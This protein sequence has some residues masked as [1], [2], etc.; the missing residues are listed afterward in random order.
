MYSLVFCLVLGAAPQPV[1]ES[2]LTEA[3]TAA[4]DIVRVPSRYRKHIRYLSF[5]ALDREDIKI[6]IV[7]VFNYHLNSLSDQ[8][9]LTKVNGKGLTGFIT[10]TL[11]RVYVK[12]F[13]WDDK[14]KLENFEKLAEVDTRFHVAVKVTRPG[15][16]FDPK[17]KKLV[18]KQAVKKIDKGISAPWLRKKDMEVLTKY[19]QSK[20]PI[21]WGPWFFTQTA[22]QKGRVAGYYTWFKLKNRND[23]FD[24][25]G[26]DLKKRK[27]LLSELRMVIQKSGVAQRNR[28]VVYYE[29]IGGAWG[30]LDVVAQ[31]IRNNNALLNLN[32]DYKHDA[33][34]W[35]GFLANGLFAY[36]L[37]DDKGV[38][39][40][41]APDEIGPDTTT[42][43]NDGK[44]HPLLSCT[45]CHIE[46]LRPIKDYARELF[47]LKHGKALIPLLSKDEKKQHRLSQLYLRP[48]LPKLNQDV[49]RFKEA[50]EELNGKDWTPAV[51]SQNYQRAWKEWNDDS[52]TLTQAARECGVT[53]SVLQRT[54]RTYY[55]KVKIANLVLATYLLDEPG[56]ILREHWEEQFP[57]VMSLLMGLVP[58]EKKK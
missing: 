45:R 23:Y 19:T 1:Q 3:A 55:T 49:R 48:F 35:F 52:V 22:I 15:F 34:E 7:Y 53:V 56:E 51:N 33:E 16:D 8:S 41:T 36:Y 50:L 27:T 20:A 21:L 54:L 58:E 12:D 32:G 30:T 38:Q 9:K 39:Q 26:L 47:S 24:L 43:S 5:Y 14:T 42:T 13:G 10:P 31:Q 29:G 46:G 28:G 6:W 40:E 17:T 2:P 25:I 57:L 44:I 11:L 18:K 4:T 37:C